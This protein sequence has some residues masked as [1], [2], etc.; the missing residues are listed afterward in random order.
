MMD[1]LFI[2]YMSEPIINAVQVVLIALV[3]LSIF[4]LTPFAVK[5]AFRDSIAF[6]TQKSQDETHSV[7]DIF[8]RHN[9]LAVPKQPRVMSLSLNGA[10]KLRVANNRVLSIE[11]LLRGLNSDEERSA[12]MRFVNR[13][14]AQTGQPPLWAAR[15]D[16][17]FINTGD[18]RARAWLE[19][20]GFGSQLP[21]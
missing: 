8:V 20:H 17:R 15:K 1:A 19:Q 4:E 2:N 13:L 5:Q 18:L 3:C 16:S 9:D 14:Q 21:V 12:L 6:F 10:P 11:E 7:P